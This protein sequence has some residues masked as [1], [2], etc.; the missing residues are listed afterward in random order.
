MLISTVVFAVGCLAAAYTDF[1]RRRVPN[2]LTFGLAAAAI[3]SAAAFGPRTLGIAVAWYVATLLAGTVLFS[4]GWIGGGDVKL[5]AAGAA[6]AAWPGAI[7]FLLYVG[8]A[9]GVLAAAEL[10][11]TRRLRGALT[12]LAT[13]AYVGTLHQGVTLDRERQKLPYALAIAAGAILL[14][15]SETVAPWLQLVHV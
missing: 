1:T 2:V 13:A 7:T 4:R 6:T 10:I 3:A 9:G 14:V 8:F 5:I 12:E 15:A 11:R